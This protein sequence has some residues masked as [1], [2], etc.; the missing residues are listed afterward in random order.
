MLIEKKTVSGQL[1]AAYL[2][3]Q[4][5]ART[6]PNRLARRASA[7]LLLSPN[8]RWL[9]SRNR[10][11]IVGQETNGWSAA[12]HL[13]GDKLADLNSLHSFANS[14]DGVAVMVEAYRSFDF[15]REYKHRNSAF[16]RAFRSL[17]A[18]SDNGSPRRCGPTSSR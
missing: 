7:P 18:T 11:L 1:E 13:Q 4:I 9:R 15:A 2:A 6:L 8:L 16:W 3:Y 14:T 17:E 12:P 10:L 5:A